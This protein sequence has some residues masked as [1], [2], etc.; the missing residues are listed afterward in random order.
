MPSS[1]DIRLQSAHPDK[2]ALAFIISPLI[3]V[4]VSSLFMGWMAFSLLPVAYFLACI[5][6]VP[7]YITLRAFNWL[8]IW[9]FQLAAY[10]ISLCGL[11]FFLLS[12]GRFNS[13][14]DWLTLFFAPYHLITLFAALIF[15][16]I[17]VEAIDDNEP[18][19]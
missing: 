12:L 19:S 3:S 16:W 2:I 8:N 7:A 17:A 1:H 9:A 18:A 13:T 10:L 4:G 11:L 14:H 6:G 15:W 5:L